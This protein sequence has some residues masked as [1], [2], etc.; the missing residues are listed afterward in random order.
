MSTDFIP[1][2]SYLLA[3]LAVAGVLVVGILAAVVVD[4]VVTARQATTQRDEVRASLA[5]AFGRVS[6][7]S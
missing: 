3:A 5:A 1:F 7:Q 2:V 4:S 6:H